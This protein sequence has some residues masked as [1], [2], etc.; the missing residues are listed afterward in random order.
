MACTTKYKDCHPIN[1]LGCI[2]AVGKNRYIQMIP[3][4]PGPRS[5]QSCQTEEGK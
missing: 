3:G 4:N 2:E 5:C 1:V